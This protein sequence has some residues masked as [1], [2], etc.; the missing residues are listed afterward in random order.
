MSNKVDL[1]VIDN[2]RILNS[3]A[4][5]LEP[6]HLFD[7]QDMHAAKIDVGIRR[8]KPIQMRAADRA[9]QQAVRMRLNHSQEP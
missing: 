7:R 2:T 4:R 8:W 3:L 6:N 5:W 9:K 1:Q